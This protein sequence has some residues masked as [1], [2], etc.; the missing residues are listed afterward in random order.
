MSMRN[1]IN[2]VE[3]RE[4]PSTPKYY[5]SR[6]GQVCSDYST[7]N[8]W[9]NPWSD[10]D[11]YLNISSYENGH[12]RNRKVH[13]LVAEAFIPNSDNLPLVNH[14]DEDKTNNHVSNL[15]WCTAQ[16]NMMHSRHKIADKQAR[17][18]TV[19]APTGEVL[20]GHN[21]SRF[22]EEHKLSRSHMSSV[23][24]GRRKHHQGWVKYES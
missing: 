21:L 8:Y 15:E 22:C 6:C 1:K 3:L 12:K 23:L 14:I 16:Y 18:F 4:I 5:V 7:K 20:K 13:R 17:Y 24:N 10:K 11:G 9:I 19:V 2:I